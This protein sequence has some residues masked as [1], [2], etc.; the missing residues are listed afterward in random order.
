MHTSHF[1]GRFGGRGSLV[2]G[3]KVVFEYDGNLNAE[4]F[5]NR[6]ADV[7]DGEVS[8]LAEPDP[9]F[10]SFAADIDDGAV[11]VA[12]VLTEGFTDQEKEDFLPKVAELLTLFLVQVDDPTST[13]FV[14]RVFPHWLNSYL[15]EAVIAS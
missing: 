10:V 14:H 9:D 8:A 11:D 5:L 1:E 13:L 4:F 12:T 3:I 15:E 7:L 2:L 6:T